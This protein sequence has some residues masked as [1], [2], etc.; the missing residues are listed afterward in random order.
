MQCVPLLACAPQCARGSDRQTRKFPL[1]TCRFVCRH[2]QWTRIAQVFRCAVGRTRHAVRS[3]AQPIAPI[4]GPCRAPTS[5]PGLAHV[6]ATT[7]RRALAAAAEGSMAQCSIALQCVL[8]YGQVRAVLPRRPTRWARRTDA[9]DRCLVLEVSRRLQC[10]AAPCR[11]L[12]THGTAVRGGARRSASRARCAP[13]NVVRGAPR[14]ML[15]HHVPR[16]ATCH[17]RAR[18]HHGW[19]GGGEGARGS[20]ADVDISLPHECFEPRP[21]WPPRAHVPGRSR[22]EYPLRSALPAAAGPCHVARG[23]NAG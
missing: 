20:S 23:G 22:R 2:T 16:R 5:A 4:G 7:G 12:R 14:L 18:W 11:T 19:P 10:S 15:I 9:N 3:V 8:T 6:C 13:C 17:C 1:E 21:V